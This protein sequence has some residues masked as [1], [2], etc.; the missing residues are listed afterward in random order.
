M[1]MATQAAAAVDGRVALLE[2]EVRSA[3]LARSAAR[4]EAMLLKEQ[5]ARVEAAALAATA[6]AVTIQKRA[7]AEIEVAVAAQTRAMEAADV[8]AKQAE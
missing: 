6:E 5:C 8:A 1:A 4:L 7:R 2:A 3:G